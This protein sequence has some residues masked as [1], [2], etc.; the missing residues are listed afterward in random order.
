MAPFQTLM[1]LLIHN[2]FNY[3]CIGHAYSILHM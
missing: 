1:Q 2:Y 3:S